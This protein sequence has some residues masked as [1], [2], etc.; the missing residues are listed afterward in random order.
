MTKDIEKVEF[1]ELVL[2][3]SKEIILSSSFQEFSIELLSLQI[4]YSK[5]R[6]YNYFG[7]KQNI[8]A[9]I[10]YEAL[11][12]MKVFI[13][14]NIKEY[15]QHQDVLRRQYIESNILL[16][17]YYEERPAFGQA[18]KRLDILVQKE[19][20]NILVYVEENSKIE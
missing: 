3:K 15:P 11:H 18:L 1:I 7:D 20:D 16:K 5:S 12:A 8:L 14:D 9:I 17:K 10:I 19:E 6:V 13:M 2:R 4:R